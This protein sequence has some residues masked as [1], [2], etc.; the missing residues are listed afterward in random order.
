MEMTKGHRRKSLIRG[1]PVHGWLGLGLV[2]IFWILNWSLSGLRTH[3]AFFPLWLGYCLLVD[4]LVFMRK[5]HSMLTRNPGAY[6]KLFLVSAPVWWLFELLNWRT[7]NWFYEGRQFFTDFQYFVL[8]SLSFSTVMP[9]VFG[10]AELVSTFNWLARMRPSLPPIV[11]ARATLLAFFAAGWLMLALL[12]LWPL[13]FFPFLWL[14]LYFILEP[15]NVWLG[16]RSLVQHTAGGDWRPILALGIGCLIC[17]FFWEMWNFYSYPKWI[18]QVPFVDFL[19]IFEMP[20]LGY[21]GYLPFA[22]ELF[23]SYHL[24]MG[25]LKQKEG[26]GFIQ[27]SATQP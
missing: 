27:V 14:S 17:S 5:G 13:Y 21:G 19:H 12:L 7:Q 23:A 26:R 3:W 10:T 20:L 15:L 18:Y 1:W 2:I 8:A 16:N 25:L 4:A 6:V 11:L 22:L 24:V 9:A